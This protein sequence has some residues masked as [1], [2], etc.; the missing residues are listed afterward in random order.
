MDRLTKGW[1]VGQ[2]VTIALAVWSVALPAWAEVVKLNLLHFN[3]VYEITPVQGGQRGGLARLATLRQQLLR[4]NPRTYTILAGDFLS[5]SAL[6]TAKVDGDRLAGRQMVATLNALGLD[7]A[8]FGNHEF[9]ISEQQFNQ[10]LQESKFQWFSSNVLDKKGAAFPNVPKSVVFNLKGTQGTIV[11]VGLMGLTIAS[12]P[13]DYVQYQDVLVSARQQVKALRDRVDVLVAVTHLSIDQDRQLAEAVPE[14]DLILGGHEHE[15]IQ[16]WRL[17]QRPA[18]SPQCPLSKTPIFK[19]DANAVTAYI[20]RL[21]YDTTT[22]CLTIASELRD[23][24]ADLPDDRRTAQVVQEWVNKGFAGFR[25]DG[26]EPQ[27]VIATIRMALDGR[28]SVVRN[29]ATP[30]TDL[31]AQSML[32]SRQGTELAIFNSGGIRIDDV[33]PAGPITQYDVIRIL[34]FG[35]KVLTVNLRGDILQKVLEIGQTNRGNG[36]YLQTANVQRDATKPVWLIQGK[37]L[38]PQ[39]V[40]RVAIND[41]L[42]SGREQNLGFLK[43]GEPGIQLVTSGED[44]RFALIQALKLLSP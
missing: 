41:F 43:L 28:E 16:Q 26:F 42:V 36:G 33:I 5:P 34:P 40:Y 25:T 15:N 4:E 24:T 44:V 35:G 37:P 1:R 13:V 31:I 9:D 27:Q 23:I 18:R 38:E 12:N 2:R 22:R 17:T 19:A 11:R 10:R 6:G 20:H 32:R 29:Q 21:S 7:Y 8:T 3:D 39:R 14:L 30:L